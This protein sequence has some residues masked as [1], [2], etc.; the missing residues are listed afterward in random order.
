MRTAY[1]IHWN[2]DEAKPKASIL[3][4][5]GFKTTHLLPNGAPSLKI[6]SKKPSSVVVIDLCRL[7][8]QGRDIGILLRRNGKT[9]QIPL[10]FVGGESA[11]IAQ[12]RRDLPDATYSSWDAIDRGLQRALKAGK[13]NLKVPDS[14][15]AGYSGTPLPAKLGIKPDSTVALVDAPE[16]FEKTLGKLPTGAALNRS[17]K[18]RQA[19]T[20]WFVTSLHDYRSRLRALAVSSDRI[21]IIWPKKSSGVATDLSEQSIRDAGLATGLVD[22]KVCAVDSTWSGLLFTHRKTP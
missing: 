6:V 3:R 17:P 11:K 21:W 1:L 16:N 19:L 22:Y 8:S 18:G 7:P 15:L 13:V 2:S 14:S 4:R 10:V 5:S 12:V 20:L 9:R